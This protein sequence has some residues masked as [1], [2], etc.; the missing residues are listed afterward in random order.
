MKSKRLNL[1]ENT[2][3]SAI[4]WVIDQTS[5]Q[6]VLEGNKQVKQMC[7]LGKIMKDK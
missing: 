1:Q 5:M 3:S 7:Q 2:A 4:Q 6:I